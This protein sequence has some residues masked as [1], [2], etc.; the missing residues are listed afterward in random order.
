MMKTLKINK[1]G[2]IAMLLALVACQREEVNPTYDPNTETVTA[3]LVFNIATAPTTKQSAAET[4]ATTSS[5]FLGIKDAYLLTMA[6]SGKSGKILAQDMD[7]GDLQNLS[8]VLGAN[9]VTATGETQKSHR[10][11]NMSLPLKTN[12][13]LFYGRAARGTLSEDFGGIQNVTLDDCYGKLE[14]YVITK[15]KGSADFRLARRLEENEKGIFYSEEKLLSGIF[16]ALMNTSIGSI[17][18]SASDGPAVATDTDHPM[19]NYDFAINKNFEAAPNNENPAAGG[20]GRRLCWA[21]FA[22]PNS[23]VSPYHRFVL[24]DNS[25]VSRS[26]LEQALADLYKQM[27]TIYTAQGELRAGSGEATLRIINDMWT[28]VN[29]IRWRD[30]NDASEALAKYFADVI[31]RHID[32]YFEATIIGR[33]AGSSM[34]GVNFETTATAVTAIKSDTDYWSIANNVTTEDFVNNYKL[35]DADYTNL[36]QS[37]HDSPIRL[38]EFPYIFD[39]PRGGSHVAFDQTNKYFYYPKGFNT[40]DMGGDPEAGGKYNAESYYYPSELLY[41]G[42]SPIRTSTQTHADT[43]YP[44]GVANWNDNTKWS[45]DWNGEYVTSATNSVAMKYNINYGVALLQTQVKF[46]E[47]ITDGKLK[48][49]NRAVQIRFRGETEASEERDQEIT[50]KDGMFRLTGIIIGGQPTHV[51][52]DYLPIPVP[53]TTTKT[54]G[55]VF[56]KAIHTG[57]QTWTT[58]GTSGPNYTVVF[59][60]FKGTLDEGGIYTPAANQ[61][62]VN[63]ALEFQNLTGQDFYGN[64]NLIRDRG[65]FYLIGQLNPGETNVGT[66]D[67]NTNIGYPTGKTRENFLNRDDGY[68][69]PPYNADGTSQKVPRVFIQDYITKATFIIGEHA[70]KKAY[71][72]VPDLR[73]TSMS[74]GLSVDM[75]WEDGLIFNVPIN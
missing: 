53:G 31:Y 25:T 74:L 72:T 36:G 63:I 35:L 26:A 11:M 2:A 40:N 66:E 41:F 6:E 20:I 17:N 75:Q 8:D 3:Q 22:D 32:Q 59:D 7:A 56:D 49:N 30:P 51:G 1:L 46:A 23:T 9:Q 47:N 15:Q 54:D 37:L 55:F 71:L 61:D 33:G 73:A 34:G 29:D 64:Y 43:D 13:L 67:P 27:T 12:K 42:N 14:Q 58:G 45:S 52:W 44:D 28:L 39:L 4:Q 69:V 60:N 5:S 24:Q 16:T 50:I 10:V 48:D 57:A 68:V 19:P 38:A 70:L 65:Y 62:V 18:I 21:D